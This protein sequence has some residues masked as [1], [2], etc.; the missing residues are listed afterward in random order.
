MAV[1]EVGEDE[2][3]GGI[4]VVSAIVGLWMRFGE[5]VCLWWDCGEKISGRGS[6][7][8]ASRDWALGNPW[9]WVHQVNK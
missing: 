5:S 6:R 8:L 4:D 9:G 3:G 1:M 7:W 2:R